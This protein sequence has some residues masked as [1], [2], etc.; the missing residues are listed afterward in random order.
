MRHWLLSISVG[1]VFTL[2]SL[3]VVALN[4]NR[5]YEAASYVLNYGG[6]GATWDGQ[7]LWVIDEWGDREFKQ[8]S[9]NPFG[10]VRS[11]PINGAIGEGLAWDGANL[12]TTGYDLVKVDP[13]DGTILGDAGMGSFGSGG[14]TFDGEYFWKVWRPNFLKIDADQSQIVDQITP[15]DTGIDLPGIE[16]GLTYDGEYLYVITYGTGIPPR[17]YK[18]DP[19]TKRVMPDSFQL[20]PGTYNGLA[21]DGVNLWAVNW[22]EKTLHKVTD[23]GAVSVDIKPAEC[24]NTVSLNSKG[25]LKVAIVADNNLTDVRV[26]KATSIR[27]LGVPPTGSRY[28]DVT[29]PLA[30]EP[31]DCIE[32]GP[33]GF[34][35]VALSFDTQA[36]IAAVETKLGR[37][38][39]NNEVVEVTLT[40]QLRDGTEIRGKDVI[41]FTSKKKKRRK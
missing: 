10:L 24:P 17:I 28:R 8:Y 16:E 32:S 9:T 1:L 13:E 4:L 5:A 27:L 39:E 2:I 26:V 37:P 22:S 15:G 3:P 33:D 11:I 29:A 6:E 36:V 34:K 41:V 18:I 19:V 31:P 25:H 30:G 35:D 7:H 14:L 40:G 21:F 23:L 38:P 20:P 12:W